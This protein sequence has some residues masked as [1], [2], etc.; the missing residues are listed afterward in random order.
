[1]GVRLTAL[2]LLA[3]ESSAPAMPV[4]PWPLDS[5]TG[6]PLL[7][8]PS[9]VPTGGPLGT[10]FPG[11]PVSALHPRGPQECAQHSMQGWTFLIPAGVHHS[12]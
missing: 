6:R 3:Q 10:L 9:G 12:S 8:T 2:G 4:A 7:T 1:M 11:A 5:R